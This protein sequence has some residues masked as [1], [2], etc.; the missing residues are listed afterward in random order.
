MQRNCGNYRPSEGRQAPVQAHE[1]N[2]WQDRAATGES[3][4]FNH[5]GKGTTVA[6]IL[7]LI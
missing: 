7:W 6:R 3:G 5:E 2:K 4:H 1:R